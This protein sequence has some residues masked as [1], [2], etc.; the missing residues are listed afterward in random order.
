MRDLAHVAVEGLELRAQ[1][2]DAAE[3]V[4]GGAGDLRSFETLCEDAEALADVVVEL[5]GDVLT[6]FLLRVEEMGGEAAEL[7]LG[8][9]EGAGGDF[10]TGL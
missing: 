2:L 3:P 10:Y 9:I 1:S 4:S 5:A 7:V 6:F 8:L